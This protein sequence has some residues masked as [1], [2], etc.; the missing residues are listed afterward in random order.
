MSYFVFYVS[1]RK[2]ITSVEETCN[3]VVP[4]RRG[5]LF[6]L[7]LVRGCVIDIPWNFHIII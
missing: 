4:V 6:L 3:Y 2:S 5:F 1:C 7:V